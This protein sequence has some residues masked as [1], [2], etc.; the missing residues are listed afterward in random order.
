MRRVVLV[1]ALAL[2]L[3][4]LSA[5]V[6]GHVDATYADIMGCEQGCPAAAAGFPFPFVVD[7]PGISPVGSVSLSGALLGMDVVWWGRAAAT[8][9]CWLAAVAAG[10]EAARR[11]RRRSR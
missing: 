2:G 6:P 11:A 4:L 8:F 3:T 5:L 7:Y 9:A 10:A 1:V